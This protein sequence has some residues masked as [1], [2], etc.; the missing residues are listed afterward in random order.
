MPRSR[1]VAFGLGLL[2]LVVAVDGPP[3]VF[4]DSSFLAHMVQHLMLQLVAVPLLLLGGPVGLV[5]RADPPWLR[6]RVLVRVLRS[7][8][9]RVL[10]HP[11][12]ALAAFAALLVGSHLTPLYEVALQHESVHQLEHLGYLVT[13]LLFWWPALGVDPA[14]H[15][16]SHPGR[17]LYLL[18]SMPVMAFLGVAIADSGHVLYASYAANPPPWG[19]SPIADQRAAGTLMWVSGMFTVV[20]AMAAVLWQWLEEDSRRQRRT[21]ELARHRPQGLPSSPVTPV[22]SVSTGRRR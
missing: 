10:T 14:P 11:V 9:V 1:P 8:T 6:R 5:L 12:T 4:S 22:G 21:D 20:P 15:R 7:H 18:L 19:A 2:A 17:L 13:A 3:D 16:L